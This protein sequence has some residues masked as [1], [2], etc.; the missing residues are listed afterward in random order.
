[1]GSKSRQRGRTNKKE[2]EIEKGEKRKWV[3]ANEIKEERGWSRNCGVEGI[4]KKSKRTKERE[5]DS[6]AK[7]DRE[8]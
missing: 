3:W 5:V 7:G 1:M 8:T 6:N 2:G 4:W